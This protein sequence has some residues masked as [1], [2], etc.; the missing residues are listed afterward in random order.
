MEDFTTNDI[1]EVRRFYRLRNPQFA[2][3]IREFG[4]FLKVTWLVEARSIHLFHSFRGGERPIRG[5]LAQ[6]S[7]FGGEHDPRALRLSSTVF[8]TAGHR[9]GKVVRTR[10]AVC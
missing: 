8:P 6:G 2:A 10:S 5:A 7:W 3:S 4:D 1:A 9:P